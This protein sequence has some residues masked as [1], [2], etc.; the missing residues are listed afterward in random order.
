[1]LFT[2]V[3]AWLGFSIGLLSTAHADA[4][5]N[6]RAPIVYLA[7]AAFTKLPQHIQ[8]AL[9]ARGCFIPQAYNSSNPHNVIS[10]SFAARGQ[11]DWAVI[12]STNGAS[13]IQVFWGGKSRCASTISSVRDEAF[14]QVD[15]A[16]KVVYSREIKVAAE[17]R[18]FPQQLSS[19]RAKRLSHDGI[20][21]AFIGKASV[22]HY[23]VQGRWV[24][25]SGAD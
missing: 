7:P 11:R 8:N 25:L 13:S 10:G 4:S 19:A 12:C 18:V 21:D 23:C 16:G 6:A 9:V 3:L 14:L 20:E 2:H 17:H 1:M 24:E 22:I 5:P 15:A